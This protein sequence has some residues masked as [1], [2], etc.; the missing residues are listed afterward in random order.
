[1][2]VMDAPGAV[3]DGEEWVSNKKRQ[4]LKETLEG[5]RSADSELLNTSSAGPGRRRLQGFF[6]NFKFDWSHGLAG[7]IGFYE[8]KTLFEIG[9]PQFGAKAW[10]TT[11]NIAY[12]SLPW[13]G[14]ISFGVSVSVLP[15]FH[16]AVH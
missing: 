12:A 15:Y 9:S 10:A 4:L 14:P 13:E 3:S 11:D 1:M 8:H 6:K 16:S 7:D 2:T 5:S